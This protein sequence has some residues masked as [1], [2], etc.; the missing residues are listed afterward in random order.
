MPNLFKQ[1]TIC[2]PSNMLDS[3]EGEKQSPENSTTF[4]GYFPF[5][6]RR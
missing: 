4:L 5:S 6:L 3:I 1:V 2:L